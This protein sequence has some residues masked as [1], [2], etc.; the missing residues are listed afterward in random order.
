MPLQYLVVDKDGDVV[1]PGEGC[2]G[3]P[4]RVLSGRGG[5]HRVHRTLKDARK[6][7]RGVRLMF[8]PVRILAI[9]E[10]LTKNQPGP[11]RYAGPKPLVQHA[12][13]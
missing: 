9:G 8:H 11:G 12:P 1:A 2:G 3:T 5:Q 4:N 7:A 10:V 6:T 13:A